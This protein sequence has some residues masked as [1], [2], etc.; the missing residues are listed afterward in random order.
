MGS[1]PDRQANSINDQGQAVSYSGTCN[2]SVHAVLWATGTACPLPDLGQPRSNL[3][4][5]IN[6][7]GQIVGQVRSADSTTRHAALWQNGVLTDL[8]VLPEDFGAVAS[9][10]NN[11]G[12]VVGSN[13]DSNFN[14]IHAF[15]WQ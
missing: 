13:R 8:G 6:N 7:Q 3:A 15:I 11:Q 4:F 10:I 14:F 9:G 12:Q 5:A 1:N 2:A